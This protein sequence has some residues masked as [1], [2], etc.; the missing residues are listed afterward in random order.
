[1]NYSELIELL[2]FQKTM[3]V[4]ILTSLNKNEIANAAYSLG[5]LMASI[6][7]AKCFYLED[8]EYDEDD[9]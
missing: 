4:K 3:G 7:Q 6:Q 1:M 5:L 2:D 8:Y 9:E